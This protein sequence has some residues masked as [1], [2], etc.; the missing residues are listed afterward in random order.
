MVSPSLP[1]HTCDV[2]IIGGGPAGLATA[3]ELAHHGVRSVVIEPRVTVSHDRP[4]AKTTSI[5]TMEHFR[6]WGIADLVRERAELKPEWSQRVIFCDTITGSV[7]T[8][9]DGAFGLSSEPLPH[10]AET[11]QQVPQPVVEEVLREHVE[12]TGLVTLRLGER[13]TSVIEHDHAVTV[14]LERGDGTTTALRAT[15]LVGA[16][17]GWSLS[18]D[19]IGA[20][21]EG[22]SAP[23]CNL[24]V[25]FTSE[26]LEP[27]VGDAIHYWVLGPTVP[28]GLGRL[29][30]ERR[31][32]AGLAGAGHVDDADEV[33]RMIADLVG[34]DASD[35]DLQ[36]ESMDPWTPRMLLADRF[37]SRRIFLV[38]ESAHLNP[39][40]GGHG[41]NTCVGDA[42]NIGWKLAAVLQGWG[43]PQLLQS[44]ERERRQVAIATIDS[45]RAN[46]QASGAGIARTAEGL[47]ATKAEEFYSLGLVLGYSYAGSPIVADGPVADHVDVQHYRPTFDPGA[48]LPHAW[49]G[50]GRSLYDA[51]GTGFTLLASPSV[52]SGDLDRLVAA[53][54]ERSIPLTVVPLPRHMTDEHRHLVLVRPDQHIAW[55]GL[56]TA[57]LD[58]DRL[59]GHPTTA[60]AGAHRT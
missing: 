25:V 52:D 17:G 10:A 11:S 49:L 3:A 60:V 19:A 31:W 47:Q 34:R 39:P 22:S 21:L 6:R 13:A 45:A 42:V 51:L 15:Y 24:N 37:A 16:D 9:F 46:L 2:A 58:L 44:Y 36:I 12:R 18:R 33:T 20:V 26:L 54:S 14:T 35:L 55:S 7:I 41:F 43:G 53:F 59:T 57:D 40:F 56:D 38:G 30:H 50:P 23:H 5:R 29:D 27:T 8:H 4:R 1:H 32:W 28:G 48:R